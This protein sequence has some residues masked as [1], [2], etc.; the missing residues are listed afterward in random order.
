MPAGQSL[1]ALFNDSLSFD[2]SGSNGD[3]SAE[4]RSMTMVKWILFG[5]F[6]I[7][8]GMTL[9]GF[10][11]GGG[12]MALVLGIAGVVSGILFLINR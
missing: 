4:T 8:H 5:L 12:L 2:A 11:I 9:L 1:N 7:L 10:S 6:L 3:S